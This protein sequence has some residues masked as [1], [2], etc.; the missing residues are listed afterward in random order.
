MLRLEALLA[1][2]PTALSGGQR[3]RVA[4]G[5]AIVREPRIFLFDE[6]LSNLDAELRVG[7]R[8]ELTQLHKRLR[9]TMIYVTHDQV[10]AMTMAD[11]IVVLRAGRVEQV[12]PPLELYNRPANAVRGRVHRLAADEFLDGHGWSPNGG[13][14]SRA[15]GV[16]QVRRGWSE[17]S[18][19]DAGHPAGACARRAG[20]EPGRPGRWRGS[21][22]SAAP[23]RSGWPTPDLT[24]VVPGQTRLRYGE[25]GDAALA[26]RGAAC[27]RCRGG[28]GS[29]TP[30]RAARLRGR[31]RA[32]GD[33]RTAAAGAPAG[34]ACCGPALVRVLFLPGGRAAAGPDLD[35]ARAADADDMPW[36][37]RDRLDESA[38]P[39]PVFDLVETERW[40]ADPARPPAL[41]LEITLA[42]FGLAWKLPDGR[43]F[44]ADRKHGYEF[45]K[46]GARPRAPHGPARRR[47]LLRARRQDRPARPARP[48]A[49]RRR[50]G[51][52][53]LRRRDAATRSISTGRS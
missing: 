3:Q 35:G 8:A 2:K 16:V 29:V 10:E 53:R 41:S 46:R 6:P 11:R 4:I 36:E 52:P 15:S 22:S 32:R 50:A 20:A 23:A 7:M 47:P 24:A 40:R 25:H 43:V 44:A 45:A 39:A 12:G 31:N 13:G 18:G 9:T 19:G 26:A 28:R 51:Q 14:C 34:S 37:G 33:D 38:W 27:V 49:A 30:I 5:R 17:G 42:P 21:S 48:P 1:R